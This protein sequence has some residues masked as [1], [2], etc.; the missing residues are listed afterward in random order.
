M[1]LACVIVTMTI[2]VGVV[3]GEEQREVA[4]TP[5]TIK[6]P[7]VVTVFASG[8]NGYHTYRIPAIVVSTK[9]TL[10]AF[11]E[12]RMS[13]VSDNGN[14]DV[15]LRRS[16][17]GGRTWTPLQ[18]VWDEGPNVCGNP[19]AVVDRTTG[20]IWLHKCGFLLCSPCWRW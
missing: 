7:G 17:D 9:G 6:P 4:K 5:N 12:G 1:R 14:I 20:T 15:V 2:A 11:C 10:L 3:R 8:R 18:L 16:L 19:S 13:G